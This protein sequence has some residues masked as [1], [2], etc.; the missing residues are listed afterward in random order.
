M[1]RYASSPCFVLLSN[2]PSTTQLCD[3]S[4]EEHVL[5]YPPDKT[6]LYLH[7]I[8]TCT[9]EFHTLPPE[10]VDAFADEWG[11]IKTKYIT[12]DSITQVRS[13]TDDIRKTG[14]WEGE[15]V[16]GFVVRTHI[17]ESPV[18]ATRADKSTAGM[19][20]YAPGSTFFFKVKFDEPYL[21]YRDWREV[22]KSL[23][24][25]NA[26]NGSM[27]PNKLSRTKMLRPE[28]KV[29]VDWVV[30]EIK[31][32]PKAFAQYQNNKGIIKTREM[33]LEWLA[34]NDGKQAPEEKVETQPQPKLRFTKT[35]IVPIAIP[36]CGK[37][38][39]SVA[40]AHIFKFGH[41]QSDDV[42]AKKPGPAFV[43]NVM[44]LLKTHDVVI[45][46]KYVLSYHIYQLV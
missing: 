45:A 12:L 19:L 41:T 13:F 35:I 33:F 28:T 5:P 21:M 18:S 30:K 8:N 36:G 7:G 4:F 17:T 15:P 24:T 10:A 2:S 26:K 32:N 14:T 38:A 3:D 20:P 22:T 37:T 11:F 16:E 40:L 34:S 1:P 42:R 29:Y 25:M 23:L 6:G 44:E 43:R 46:D 27:N 9:K 31:R 39:V